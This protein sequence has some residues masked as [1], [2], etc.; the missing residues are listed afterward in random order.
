MSINFDPGTE[1]ASRERAKELLSSATFAVIVTP[2]DGMCFAGD[3]TRDLR[4]EE[5]LAAVVMGIAKSIYLAD[6]VCAAVAKETGRNV[7]SLR[8]VVIEQ[9][10]RALKLEYSGMKDIVA[11]LRDGEST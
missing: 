5:L 1:G 9:V 4:S 6:G 8:A 7:F 2:G 3:A 10:M 11:L